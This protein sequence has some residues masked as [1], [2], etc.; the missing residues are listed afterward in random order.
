MPAE[1][2]EPVSRLS[3]N[4]LAVPIA[5]EALPKAIPR[6]IVW[7]NLKILSKYGPMIAPVNP[8]I[9]TKTAV[10]DGIPPI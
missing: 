10:N 9:I 2:I 8:A 6:A 7:S 4:A 5:W 3:S 1:L